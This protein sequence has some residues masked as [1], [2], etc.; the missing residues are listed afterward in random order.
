LLAPL[1]V[2]ALADVV[3]MR[4]GFGIV[5]PL[6]VAAAI[7][8]ALAMRLLHAEPHAGR[9]ASLRTESHP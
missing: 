3:G 5:A 7:C 9:P 2:G 6:L 4:W 1:V 8:L